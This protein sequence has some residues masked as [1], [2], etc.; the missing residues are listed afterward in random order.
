VLRRA[1]TSLT[2]G[3][4]QTALGEGANF[5]VPPARLAFTDRSGRVVEP[6]E[7]ELWVG[8]SCANRET[9]AVVDL[10]GEVHEIGLTSERLTAV[11]VR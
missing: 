1:R 10:Q 7:W 2:A 9:T 4:E 5:A 3:P 11:N 8:P 6:G